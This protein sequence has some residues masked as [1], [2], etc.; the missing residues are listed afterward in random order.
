MFSVFGITM[1]ER[2]RQDINNLR[3]IEAIITERFS[4]SP[5]S[6]L[7]RDSS[8]QW[9]SGIRSTSTLDN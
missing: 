5:R 2:T 7:E 3:R 9:L 1:P 4:Y 6:R 8:F